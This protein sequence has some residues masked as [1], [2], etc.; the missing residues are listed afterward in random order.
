M[1]LIKPL[2]GRIMSDQPI[3]AKTDDGVILTPE[4]LRIHECRMKINQLCQSYGLALVPVVQI[5]GRQ[6]TTSVELAQIVVDPDTIP[7]E[8]GSGD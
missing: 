5:I 6:I 4:K 7:V 8:K 2:G 3:I 1:P